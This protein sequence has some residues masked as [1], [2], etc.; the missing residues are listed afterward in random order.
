MGSERTK[1]RAR[2][3]VLNHRHPLEASLAVRDVVALEV[4]L[5]GDGDMIS[6]EIW[7]R[8]DMCFPARWP[9]LGGDR[10]TTSLGVWV[11]LNAHLFVRVR[12]WRDTHLSVRGMVRF[13]LG[14]EGCATSR[15]RGVWVRVNVHFSIRVW[16]WQDVHR[17][18]FPLGGDRDVAFLE[19]RV[20]LDMDHVAPGA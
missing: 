3:E 13:P 18:R 9:P 7:I 12:V 1:V 19:V 14:S 11:R 2:V 15:P 5:G 16:V 6:R 4:S 17:P 20:W 8:Q 10:Y